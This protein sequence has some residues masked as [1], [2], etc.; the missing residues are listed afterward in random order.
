MLVDGSATSYSEIAKREGLTRARVTQI[1]N[2]LKLPPEWQTFLAGLD[3]PKDI[4]RYSERRL[5]N[6]RQSNFPDKPPQKK[7]KPIPDPKEKSSDKTRIKRKWS[8][9]VIA[10]EIDEE[11]SP[12]D[13]D[14]LRKL[15]QKAALRKIKE[16]SEV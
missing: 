15:I 1:M 2:L 13:L 16:A 11:V 5:R 3:N 4:R 9:D 6:Y 12:L 10:V 14:V 8:P 7:K